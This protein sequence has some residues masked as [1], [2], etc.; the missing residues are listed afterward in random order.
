MFQQYALPVIKKE[1]AKFVTD[2]IAKKGKR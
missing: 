2:F 1:G